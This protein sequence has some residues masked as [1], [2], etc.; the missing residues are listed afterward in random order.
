M[1]KK[2]SVS[3]KTPDQSP[4][5]P[6]GLIALGAVAF[7]TVLIIQLGFK[8]QGSVVKREE[9]KVYSAAASRFEPMA[10]SAAQT[11]QLEPPGVAKP[12]HLY[13]VK[14]GRNAT[15]GLAVLGA[16]EASARTYVANALLENGARLTEIY[17]D[18]VVLSRKGEKFTLYL[19]QKGKSDQVGSTEHRNLTVGDFPAPP[20]PL[21]PPAV[22][23]SDALRVAPV[24]QGNQI[25]GFSVYPGARAGQF[26]RWGLKNGDVLVSLAGQPLSSSEQLD[27]FLEQLKS[28]SSLTGEVMRGGSRVVVTLDGAT[29]LAA[30]QP[31]PPPPMPQ[32]GP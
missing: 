17:A 3:H 4:S 16:A 11:G 8:H 19:P 30:A 10:V 25:A 32:A 13:A 1:K 28:G 2:Q 23:V 14:V 22:R 27:G 9:S 31:M 6:W 21:T 29:L 24:Y 7:A 12:L 15:E 20:P 5:R 18:H 26:E